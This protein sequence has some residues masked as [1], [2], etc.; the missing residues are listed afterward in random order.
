AADRHHAAHRS[1]PQP[2]HARRTAVTMA[3]AVRKVALVAHVGSSVGWLGAVV[4]S[5]VVAAAGLASRDGQIVRAAYL[6]LEGIGWC[7]P[8]PPRLPPPPPRPPPVLGPP[9]GTA[10]SLLGSGEAADDPVRDRGA[11]ALHAA[12]DLPGRPRAPREHRRRPGQPAR[13]FPCRTC[14]SRR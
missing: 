1:W 13:P 3:P 6:T 14:R 11:A 2:A 5:L 4:T 10:A 9:L 8:H 7:L 12:P